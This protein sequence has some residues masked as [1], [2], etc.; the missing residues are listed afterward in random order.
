MA[1]RYAGTVANANTKNTTGFMVGAEYLSTS[2]FGSNASD[3]LVGGLITTQ[4]SSN[5]NTIPK[6]AG[7]LI[8]HGTGTPT[9]I[10][11]YMG[12]GIDAAPSAAVTQIGIMNKND[13]ATIADKK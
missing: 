12:L 13:Y 6:V 10:T 11:T 3:A 5:G 8:L 4:Y 9:G 1:A 7:L 2:V